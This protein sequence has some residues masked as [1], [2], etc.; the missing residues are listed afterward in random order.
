MEEVETTLNL[1][2]ACFFIALTLFVTVSL[3][4]MTPPMTARYSL[5]SLG[6]ISVYS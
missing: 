5:I 2:S 4:G 3:T 1:L 6:L